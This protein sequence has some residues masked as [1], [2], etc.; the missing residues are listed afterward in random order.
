MKRIKVIVTSR[1]G[2][3]A[4]PASLI[5]ETAK[6]FKSDI[7]LRK[8]ENLINAKSLI[9]I[10]SIGANKGDYLEVLI[11]GQDEEEALD[12]IEQVFKNELVNC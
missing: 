3:H 8:N 10:L 1:I 4:R 5:V 6:S 12:A 7:K 9:G 11:D 2:L